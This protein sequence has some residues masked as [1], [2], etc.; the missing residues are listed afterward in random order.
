MNSLQAYYLLGFT[1]LSAIVNSF[2]EEQPI[3]IKILCL[4]LL[5]T[6]FVFASL[7]HNL[8]NITSKVTTNVE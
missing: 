7:F 5:F 6:T 3:S 1:L 4:T 2:I 8:K